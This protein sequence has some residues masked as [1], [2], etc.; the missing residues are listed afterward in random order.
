MNTF[1]S[2]ENIMI[3]GTNTRYFSMGWSYCIDGKSIH[4][5]GWM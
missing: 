1:Y 4:G 2:I 3:S 5:A